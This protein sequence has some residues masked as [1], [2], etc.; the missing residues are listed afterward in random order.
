M[1]PSLPP[2]PP[3]RLQEWIL[4]FLIDREKSGRVTKGRDLF[5]PSDVEPLVSMGLVAISQSHEIPSLQITIS[6]STVV[7]LTEAGRHY[8][9]R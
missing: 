9:E 2:T 8:F 6:A 7:S 5:W 1:T 3:T 4:F